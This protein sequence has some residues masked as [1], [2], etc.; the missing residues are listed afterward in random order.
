VPYVVGMPVPEAKAA[1]AAKGFRARVREVE[2]SACV[3]PR[4]LKQYPPRGWRRDVGTRVRLDVS[5]DGMG[6]CGLDLPPAG[7]ALD[8]AGRAFVDFARGG[9]P[10]LPLLG[11]HVAL[12]L[13]GTLLHTIPPQRAAHRLGYGWLCPNYDS[14]SARAC[15]FSAVR[16]IATYP[17]PMAVTSDPPGTA[18]GG[19]RSLRGRFPQTVTLLP[20]EGRS[21]VDYFAVELA[22]GADGRLQAVNLIWSEP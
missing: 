3:K 13:G 15:P 4:V 12:H 9:Q 22:I 10:H 19:G 1:V 7:P 2:H 21:C 5:G 16:A 20:D 11:N 8:A 6:P 14:Y 17:G 18:C